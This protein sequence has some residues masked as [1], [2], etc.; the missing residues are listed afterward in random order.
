MD[1]Q[2]IGGREE[3][4]RASCKQSG[5]KNDTDRRQ[6]VVNSNKTKQVGV[7]VM[8][9]VSS[10]ILAWTHSVP[11]RLQS[12]PQ[13]LHTYMTMIP[14]FDKGC[15]ISINFQLISFQLSHYLMLH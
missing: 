8:L 12:L 5:Q 1:V 11:T 2:C 14:Q 10:S 6:H 4:C 9:W 7:M 3:S 15:F 13:H